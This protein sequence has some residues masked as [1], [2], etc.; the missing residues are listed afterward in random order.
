MVNQEI[1]PPAVDATGPVVVPVATAPNHQR[2][3][4]DFEPCCLRAPLLPLDRHE[5]GG[6]DQQP[7]GD[8][9][10]GAGEF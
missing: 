6:A 7:N 5:D 3:A 8:A 9:L 4:A 2:P 10:E 1:D